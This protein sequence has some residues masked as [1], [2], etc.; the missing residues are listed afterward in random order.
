MKIHYAADREISVEV[1]VDVLVRSTLAERRPVEDRACMEAMLRH[2][3]LLCTAW[4]GDL[5]VG[6][7]RSVTDFQYCCYLSDLAVDE[8]Y[9][10]R[11]VGRELIRVTRSR[12]GPRARLILLAAPKAAEYYQPL[13]FEKHPSA[14]VLPEDRQISAKIIA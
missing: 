9:Q 2:A 8:R 6:V 4:A 13:G 11:G 14:W 1:F 10:R 12:L 7:A 5:L 3:G